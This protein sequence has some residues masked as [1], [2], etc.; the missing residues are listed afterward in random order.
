MWWRLP[1]SQWTA[2]KGDKNKRAFKSIV[3]AGERPGIIAY[4]GG[5][6][7]AWCA[8][9]PRQSFPGLE[10]SR[11]LKP[12]DDKPAWAVTCF[13]VSKPFRGRGLSVKLLEAAKNFVRERGG[14]ILEGYPMEPKSGRLPEAFAWTGLASAFRKAGFKEAAR[15]GSRPIM[16]CHLLTFRP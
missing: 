6:P 2:Q 10:R 11:T 5:Q 14:R 4:V 3:A 7:A 16:R 13:F 8:V 9:G 1:R 15:R 12:L